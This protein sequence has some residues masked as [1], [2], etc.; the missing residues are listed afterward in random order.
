MPLHQWYIP[1]GFYTAEDKAKI[2]AAITDMYHRLIARPIAKLLVEVQFFEL[3]K[4]DR[5]VG[6]EATDNHIQIRFSHV[7]QHYA[8]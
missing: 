8:T 1:R 3:D 7:A 4:I 6:G 2:A 5:F